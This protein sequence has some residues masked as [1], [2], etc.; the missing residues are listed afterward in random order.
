[1]PVVEHGRPGDDDGVDRCQ[2]PQDDHH[3]EQYLAQRFRLRRLVADGTRLGQV[4]VEH[5]RDIDP[6]DRD[7][8][9]RRHDDDGQPTLNVELDLRMMNWREVK[10]GIDVKAAIGGR[11][12]IAGRQKVDGMDA[13]VSMDALLNQAYVPK[14]F[15]NGARPP[16]SNR[17]DPDG[18]FN[19]GAV[20]IDATYVTPI[21]HHNAMEPHATIAAWNG[22]KLTV[23]TSTQ[24]ISGAQAIP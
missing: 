5:Q 13:D 21:E 14:H 1:M 18:T 12:K 7:A 22:D 17:G 2:H 6:A 23:W 15:R 9:D 3:G 20:K 8:D 4:G 24:G 19:A 16:D 10:T 11:I